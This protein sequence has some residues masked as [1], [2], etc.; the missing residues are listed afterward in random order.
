MKGG[1]IV[2]TIRVVLVLLIGDVIYCIS[3]QLAL[4]LCSF[5]VAAM[6]FQCIWSLCLGVLDS[7]ALL[8]KRSLRNPLIVSLFVVGDWVRSSSLTTLFV[9]LGFT[10]LNSQMLWFLHFMV[11]FSCEGGRH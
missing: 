11:L 4:L 2:V 5:L 8:T 10:R 9:K 6:V 7:Y 3:P 1:I